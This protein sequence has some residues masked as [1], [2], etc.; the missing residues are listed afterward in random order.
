MPRY[1][2][3]LDDGKNRH[4][5]I[6]GTQL[7]NAKMASR[8]AMEFLASAFKS[9]SPD[10]SDSIFVVDVRDEAGQKIFTTTLMI[11]S[12]WLDAPRRD[13]ANERPVV[14]AVE[15]QFVSRMNAMDML[16]NA[17]YDVVKVGNADEAIAILEARSDIEAVFADTRIPGT[18]DGL[19]LA[20]YVHER[21][22]QIEIIATSEYFAVCEDDSPEAGHFRSKPYASRHVDE[23]TPQFQRQRA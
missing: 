19:K 18:V 22:P 21:R 4:V 2:S 15:D 5:D 8:E 23:R 10:T 14:L 16:V 7:A 9:V 20:R 12:D 13:T 3:D 6:M 11:Q 17:G 1:F